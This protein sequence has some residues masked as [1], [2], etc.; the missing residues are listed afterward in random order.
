MP[1]SLT[2][3]P[4]G[5]IQG[6][7]QVNRTSDVAVVSKGQE[8]LRS[9]AAGDSL[10][11]K[12]LSVTKGADGSRTAQI[13][14]GNN[15]IVDAK[16]QNGM[17]LSAGQTLSFSVKSS[18]SGTL[19]LTPLYQNTAALDATAS[20]ALLA[21]G[22][23]VTDEL[24]Q[25]V[26]QMMKEGMSIDK[27]SLQQMSRILSDNPSADINTLVQM[28]NLNIPINEGNIQQFQ[29]YQNYQHQV[30][31]GA[32]SIMDELPEAF[33]QMVAAGDKGQALNLYGDLMKLFAGDV[34]EAANA[35]GQDGKNAAAL[36]GQGDNAVLGLASDGSAEKGA[37]AAKAGQNHEGI[38][39]QTE[40]GKGDGIQAQGPLNSQAGTDAREVT[41]NLIAGS[42]NES[43]Q[44]AGNALSLSAK[45]DLTQFAG[46]LKNAGVPSEALNELIKAGGEDQAALLRQLSNLYEK[47]I[48]TSDNI[49][50]AW[51]KFFSSDTF[52]E[53]LK[54][55][56]ASQWT[57]G[58]GD[59]SDKENVKNLYDRLNSQVKQMTQILQSHVGEN[60]SAFQSSQ[61]LSQN[62]DFMNQLNQ[63]YAYVQLPLKMSGNDA[64]GDLYVYSNKKHMASDDGSV[65]ALLH[66]DMNN[67]GPMDVYVRM[68]DRKVNTNFYMADE[69]CIDLIAAHIDEL[70]MRLNKRGYTMNYQVLPAD[71]MTSENQAVDELLQKGDKMTLLSSSSFD[72]RA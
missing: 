66:L 61:N 58:P 39:N 60:S 2:V 15:T 63:M 67:L 57:I 6:S 47:T 23:S 20:K 34:S 42:N 32:N 25:M 71:D 36:Q 13:D 44:S 24:G 37:E 65:S 62:I 55:N 46:A 35:L 4:G 54:S 7:L 29:N 31:Y 8:S 27:Q 51:G 72:A 68:T 40:P 56:I 45:L 12:V 28:K 18:A 22:L 64:H 50:K 17:Q 48:H 49:D 59:V 16:L 43:L 38:Q 69:S 9:L 19:T 21:A 41:N 33:N 11:G 3:G 26:S 70:T 10:S 30:L 53:V 1:G 14:L 52:T 5:Q